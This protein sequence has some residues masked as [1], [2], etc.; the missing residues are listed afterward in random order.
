LITGGEFTTTAGGASSTGGDFT[1]TAGGASSTGGDFTTTAGGASSTGGE[2]TTT[3]GGASST[4][5][6]FTTTTGDITTEG[7]YTSDW[8]STTSADHT[9]TWQSTTVPDPTTL[10]PSQCIDQGCSSE[11]DGW[12]E[13]VDFSTQDFDWMQLT[14]EFDLSAGHV[15]GKCGN[16]RQE[17]CDCCKCMKAK[18]HHTTTTTPEPTKPWWHY[19][20]WGRK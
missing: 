12:G 20:S 7:E 19:Q 18:I 17:L 6:D 8:E 9:T 16:V 3:A 1:T 13:C 14:T 10:P 11:H 15:P 4:G 5:G 2:F